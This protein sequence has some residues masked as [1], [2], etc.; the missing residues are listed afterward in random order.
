MKDLLTSRLVEL[1]R[2]L[3]LIPTTQEHP[4]EI[5]R[6][7]ELIHNHIE[8]IE[9]IDIKIYRPNG[10]PS[11]VAVPSGQTRPEVMLC[12]HI[13]VVTLPEDAHFTSSMKNGRIRGPG[14]A[15]MKGPLAILLAIF[16]DTHLRRPGASLGIVVTSDEER[17]GRHGVK[18][19]FGREGL[20]CGVAII[21]DSGSL[22]RIT[23]EEKGTLHLAIRCRGPAGHAC[24]PWLV[25]NPVERLMKRLA[26]ISEFFEGMDPD[27]DHWRP[28]FSVTVLRTPNEAFN[29][30]PSEAEAVCDIRFPP[31]YTIGEIMQI[32]EQRLD[33]D[34]EV[35]ALLSAETSRYKPDPVFLEVTEEVTGRPITLFKEH[36]GS[37]ARFIGCL[38]I[39]V[40][41]SRP[42]VGN[43]HSENEWIDVNSMVSLYRIYELYLKRKLKGTD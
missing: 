12:A 4:D 41:M 26:E 42:E 34:M 38:G 40:I 8:E 16:R 43:I 2:D 32:M 7:I 31:P 14:A 10:I 30:I 5:E 25:T 21:P 3:I 20:R 1:T 11:L 22:N 23:V 18:F 19:L 37:D 35:E 9:G 28:T 29:R 27:K 36:G 6:G 39:P 24:R 17:G 15:D 13:D 33:K